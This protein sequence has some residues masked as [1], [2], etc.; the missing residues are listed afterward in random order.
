MSK[1]KHR[2]LFNRVLNVVKPHLSNT[3]KQLGVEK[4][5]QF[6]DLIGKA[7]ALPDFIIIGSQR[8][9]STSLYN[10]LIEHPSVSPTLHKEIHFFDAN[11]DKGLAWYKAHFDSSDYLKAHNLITGEASPYYLLDPEAPKKINQLIANVKLIALLRNPIDRAYSHHNTRYRKG[12][13]KLPFEAAMKKELEALRRHKGANHHAFLQ[14]YDSIPYLTRSLYAELLKPWMDIFP[15]E[16]LLIL[17]SEDLYKETSRTYQRV[18]R[19]LKLAPQELKQYPAHEQMRYSPMSAE[20]RKQL[21]EFFAPHNE[22]LHKLLGR[23]MK[24]DRRDSSSD[25]VNQMILAA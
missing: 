18:L 4:A 16:Q 9:G 23:D 10:Y 8:S 2:I 25:L 21:T 22:K 6:R 7:S 14:S 11:Y 24:W 20:T 3:L 17:R 13:E 12:M 15:K 5:V 19:F 1:P